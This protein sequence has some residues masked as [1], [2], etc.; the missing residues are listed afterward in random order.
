MVGTRQP[1]LGQRPRHVP[2]LIR[3]PTLIAHRRGLPADELD[4][5]DGVLLTSVSRTLFDLA[6]I[7]RQLLESALRKAEMR[8]LTSRR[9]WPSCSTVTPG[10]RGVTTAREA[11]ADKLYLRPNRQRAG[12][13]RS[14]TFLAAR[15]LEPPATGVRSRPPGVGPGSTACGRPRA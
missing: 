11:L 14:S 3:R 9:Q 13:R 8:R 15:G 2:A 5:D 12:G 1:T 4:I 10:R 7:D 6:A